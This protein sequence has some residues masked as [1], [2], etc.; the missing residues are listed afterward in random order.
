LNIVTYAGILTQ[1]F[2]IF[3]LFILFRQGEVRCTRLKTVS[4]VQT[5]VSYYTII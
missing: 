4:K 2:S 5:I 3:T 1:S